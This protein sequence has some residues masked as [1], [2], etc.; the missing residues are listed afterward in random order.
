[1][2]F[3]RH[4]QQADEYRSTSS[5]SLRQSYVKQSRLPLL[6]QIFRDR[7]RTI[8]LSRFVRQFLVLRN[9]TDPQESVSDRLRTVAGTLSPQVRSDHRAKHP[10][11][12]RRVEIL[13]SNQPCFLDG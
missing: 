10:R 11:R 7:G 1:M 8:T 13:P 2:A 9:D 12:G 5:S 4:T 6:F 3:S